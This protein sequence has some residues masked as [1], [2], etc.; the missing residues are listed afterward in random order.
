M[1]ELKKNF[2]K[3]TRESL[4]KTIQET[5]VQIKKAIEEREKEF[6]SKVDTIVDDKY[7]DLFSNEKKKYEPTYN[8]I[9]KLLEKSKE[10]D[11]DW[12]NPNKISSCINECLNI[13]N[14]VKT[15]N[16]DITKLKENVNVNNISPGIRF[17]PEG[18]EAINPF[19]EKLKNFG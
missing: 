18:T 5:F 15:L 7:D 3:I 1:E 12:N 14:N 8:E 11:E 19:L 2:E 6:L 16:N 10:I 13:E 4:K 9:E 17:Y